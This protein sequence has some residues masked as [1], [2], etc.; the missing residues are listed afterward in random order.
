M[1]WNRNELENQVL[2]EPVLCRYNIWYVC[3]YSQCM[4]GHENNNTMSCTYSRD[5]KAP[6]LLFSAEGCLLEIFSLKAHVLRRSSTTFV[7]TRYG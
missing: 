3:V 4:G 1:E 7:L 6:E 5:M 2:F